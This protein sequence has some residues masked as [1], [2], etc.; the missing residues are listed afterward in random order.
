MAANKEVKLYGEGGSPV[1]T[2]AEIAL[3]L[4]QV[5]YHYVYEYSPTSGSRIYIM[6]SGLLHNEKGIP[7]SL[8][9]VEYVDDTWKGYPVLPSDPYH[10]ALAHFW[11][12]FIDD[13][14]NKP[15]ITN[16]SSFV[17]IF[18]IFFRITLFK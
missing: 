14:V 9:I 10:R 3:K 1:V 11:S 15:T 6:D 12:K 8:A 5:K 4:K 2:R 16:K 7:K 13:K 17:N 18:S